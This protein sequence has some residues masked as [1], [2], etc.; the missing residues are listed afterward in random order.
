MSLKTS[1]IANLASNELRGHRQ[2]GLA[3]CFH[4]RRRRHIGSRH[5]R[6]GQTMKPTLYY[7]FGSK[8][9]LAERR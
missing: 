2:R 5:C 3:Y 8:Q 6:G 9:G 4:A 7:Y 1:L